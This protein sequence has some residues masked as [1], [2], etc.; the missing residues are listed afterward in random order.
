MAPCLRSWACTFTSSNISCAVPQSLVAAW[1]AWRQERLLTA[2]KQAMLCSAVAHWAAGILKPAFQEW[3]SAAAASA[4]H[5]DGHLQGRAL[6][7]L[8]RTSAAKVSISH[9]FA[10]AAYLPRVPSP[11]GRP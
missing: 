6:A 2:A 9:I 3:R 4:Q 8:A 10:G 7:K 5:R 11:S 1:T